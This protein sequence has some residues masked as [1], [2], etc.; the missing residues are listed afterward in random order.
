MPVW[1]VRGFVIVQYPG[2]HEPLHVHVFKDRRR[3]G[4]FNLEDRTWMEGPLDAADQARRAIRK[5]LE[6]HGL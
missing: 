3:V 5:W 6:E 2:D 1:K 4:R